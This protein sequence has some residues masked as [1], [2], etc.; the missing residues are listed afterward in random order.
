MRLQRTSLF[1]FASVLLLGCVAEPPID[2]DAERASLT[3][4]AEAYHVAG[5][6]MDT[7]ALLALYAENARLIPPD[8]DEVRGL[9]NIRAWMMGM[10][11]LTNFE[12]TFE[13]PTVEIS[14]AGDYGYS[15]ANATMSFDG[16]DSVHVSNSVRDLHV[17]EKDPDGLWKVVVDIWNEPPGSVSEDM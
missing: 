10:L 5:A 11:E 15:I 6:V 12:A 1:L 4:A 7:E 9:E 13:S 14:S 16:P 17:W 8:Q 2:L 3:A